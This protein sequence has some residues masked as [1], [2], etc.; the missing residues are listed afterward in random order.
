MLSFFAMIWDQYDAQACSAADGIHNDISSN[1]RPEAP[2]IHHP[3]F[4][5][6]DLSGAG[7]QNNL[8]PLQGIDPICNGAVFGRLYQ[9]GRSS[10]A[11]SRLPPDEQGILYRTTGQAL[12]DRYWGNYVAFL[13]SAGASN[14]IVDPTASIPCNFANQNGVTLVFSHLENCTFLD[15]SNFS[16]N[17]EHVRTLLSYDKIINGSTGLKEVSELLGGEQ[18]TICKSGSFRTR[19]WDPRAI[20][21]DVYEPP[22]DTAAEELRATVQYVVEA[23]ARNRSEI[24]VSLS[25]G[26]DSTIV[27]HCLCAARPRG[28]VRAVHYIMDSDDASE[29]HYARL[30]AEASG[31]EL[32]EIL[33]EPQ[34][35]L[36]SL[37]RHPASVRPHRQFLSPDP[38][39]LLPESFRTPGTTLMT[40]QGG[41]HLFLASQS[42]LGFADHVRN[43]GIGLETAQALVDA[44]RLSGKSIWQVLR[45]TLPP[46]VGCRGTSAMEAAIAGRWTH[47]NRH[48]QADLD[49]QSVLPDWIRVSG[50]L[51]PAKFDQVSTLLHMFQMRE[52]Y[53]KPGAVQTT[54]PLI[55][56]PLIDLCLRLPSYLLTSDGTSRGLAR[57]AFKGFIP[58]E[59]RH[60]MNKGH[61]SRYFTDRVTAYRREIVEALM[62]GELAGR[63]L[64]EPR[65]VASF[66]SDDDYRM[67]HSGS[68]LLAYYA[69]ESWLQTWKA[70]RV[71]RHGINRRS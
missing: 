13:A 68:L 17:E 39:G 6:Y 10:D 60:R 11:L 28:Q 69:I 25:G 64:I 54:H 36:D 19:L 26:L 53:F 30:A 5:I 42:P 2:S 15:V 47:I 63:G 52:P 37:G 35:G 59:I 32:I 66:F 12:I 14:V 27:L 33:A 51:P 41:D 67:A 45:K 49:R 43:H 62:Y 24:V 57:R 22:R 29:A 20:A 23:S 55:A 9:K 16:I 61:A 46:L 58:D 70:I 71:G 38:A 65:D 34:S 48:V 31:C 7:S 3:G 40:G 50:G 21:R 18:L 44:A 56:Q 4:A 8:L 1:F